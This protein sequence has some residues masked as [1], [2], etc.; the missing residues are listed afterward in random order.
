[1]KALVTRTELMNVRKI[2]FF[3]ILKQ[4]FM[5]LIVYELIYLNYWKKIDRG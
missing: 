4:F 5:E 1:M 3:N 2:I